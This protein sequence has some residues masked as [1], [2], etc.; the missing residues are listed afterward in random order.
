MELHQVKKSSSECGIEFEVGTKAGCV[1]DKAS[2]KH[3]G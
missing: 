2:K 1:K 3:E